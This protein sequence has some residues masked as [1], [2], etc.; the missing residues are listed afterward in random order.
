MKA[1]KT[2]LIFIEFQNDF[3]KPGGK[4]Y[5]SVC[6]EIARNHT[7]ENAVRLLAGARS[8][9][10]HII[11]CPFVLNLDWAEG[12]EGL[13]KNVA[14]GRVFE[15]NSWGG[16]IIDELQP[17]ENEIILKGKRGINA[18]EHTD[19][20][21][22]LASLGVENVGVAGFLTNVCAQATAWGAYDRGYRTRLIPDACGAASQEIQEY[23]EKE[24]C[25]LFGATPRV[26]EF[27][28]GLE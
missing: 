3:C 1:D 26:D 20:A 5:D 19:L 10:V 9:G 23:V 28:A 24:V 11:H 27:L 25:P 15:A 22:I 2:A 4:S 17:Q 18:F 7:I 21:H 14:D 6:D 16:A 12:K 13:F 8:K